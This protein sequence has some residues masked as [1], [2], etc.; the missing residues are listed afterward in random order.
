MEEH[1]AQGQAEDGSSA[2]FDLSGLEGVNASERIL[3]QLCRRSFLSLWAHSNLN[4]DEGFSGGKGSAK[5]LTDVLLVFGDHVVLFSDKHIVFNEDKPLD[6]AWMRW[7]RRA[8][9]HSAKQLYGAV[10]WV[11]RHPDRVFLDPQ[12]TRRL[13]VALPDSE[14]ATYHLVAVTRGS[15]PVSKRLFGGIGTLGISTDIADEPDGGRPITAGV[16]D[17]HKPFVHILD[18]VALEVVLAEF[19]TASD[20]ISYLSAR[21][22]FLADDTRVVRASGEEQLVAA[23]LLNM[24]GDS[25]WFTPALPPG[26][27]PALLVFDDGH[28]S[29]L[30]GKAAY[31]KKKEEDAPS[32]IWDE[33]VERFIRLGDPGLLSV[34][35]KQTN[36]DLEKGL[37]IIAAESRF[38]RR[39]LVR[40]FLG[41]FGEASRRPSRRH[42]RVFTSEQ[43]SER[44]YIFVV[45]PKLEG[46]SYAE[47]RKH[48]VA[49][50]GAYCFVA[51]LKFPKATIFIGL[52]FDHPSKEYSGGS[53]DLFVY[54]QTRELT[55]EDKK[56]IKRVQEDLHILPDTL[57]MKR[58]HADEF[59]PTERA[60][61]V[62]S[63]TDTRRRMRDQHRKRKQKR[64]QVKESR[65]RNR[66]NK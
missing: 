64:R 49:V 57:A 26:D 62:E 42:A 24:D 27:R 3:T 10:K 23:Y 9:Q 32:Y 31:R 61:I 60:A 33:M 51:R 2:L 16:M 17:R 25:H 48:R 38:R 19:D 59:P 22:K 21:E 18:E 4:T 30:R 12:C 8:V 65:R 35:I 47:Y 55:E 37:R 5:E 34:P 29:V 63:Q 52:G 54:E 11:K 50:L 28:Y 66:Q 20:F 15:A 1:P 44:V 13:P 58:S 40:A 43:D 46:E 14:K 6:V 7:Y 41:A 56:E 53:E 36:S 45:L 39:I